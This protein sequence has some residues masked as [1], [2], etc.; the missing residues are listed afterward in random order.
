MNVDGMTLDFINQKTIDKLTTMGLEWG[1]NIL[2][3]TIIFIIGRIVVAIIGNITER[4]LVKAKVDPLLVEFITGIIKSILLVFVIIAALEKL[5]V[6]TTSLVAVLGAAGLAIGLALQGSLQNFASGVLLI[7][8]RPFTVGHFVEVAGVNGVVERVTLF[9]TVLRT[10]DNREVTVPNG[11]IYGN[12]I[13][14][15][16]AKDTR[17][18]DMV[19][20]IAYDDDVKKA[21][22]IITEI[23]EKDERVLADPAPLVALG[24]LADSSV[25]IF[26]RPWAKTPDYWPLKY[27]LQEQ[28]KEAFDAANISIPFPQMDVHYKALS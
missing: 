26:V 21:K 6:K 28:V 1:I 23:L 10:G 3:A 16:S 7:M 5:G 12:V 27:D 19:F 25:N 22:A 9:S 18:V 13:T 2:M 15:F 17:R 24:E 4:V 8:L 20:G 14:N 11:S